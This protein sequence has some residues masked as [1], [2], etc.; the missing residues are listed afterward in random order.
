M[1]LPPLAEK[2]QN[3][4]GTVA[5]NIIYIQ[6]LFYINEILIKHCTPELGSSIAYQWTW[7]GGVR[8]GPKARVY[9]EGWSP[10]SLMTAKEPK[11]EMLEDCGGA[12]TESQEL[13]GEEV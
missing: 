4:L 12:K 2:I 9:Q 7:L 11:P 1:L 10:I 13:S 8:G 5:A 3:T 6:K